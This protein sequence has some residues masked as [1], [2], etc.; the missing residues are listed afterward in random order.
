M[1][2][3]Q[4]RGEI[5]ALVFLV[6]ILFAGLALVESA[7]TALA[8]IY[9]NWLPAGHVMLGGPFMCLAGLFL[10]IIP[11][12]ALSRKG[13]QKLDRFSLRLS[14]AA[15]CVIALETLLV[16]II[17]PDLDHSGWASP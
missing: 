1:K 15:F 9:W 4:F 13:R 2:A 3:P 10:C 17:A 12:A 16:Y 5:S 6:S 8:L 11:S 14:L 7:V